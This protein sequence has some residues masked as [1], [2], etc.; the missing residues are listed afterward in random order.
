M[1]DEKTKLEIEEVFSYIEKLR[2]KA[3]Q[4]LY[5]LG[6]AITSLKYEVKKLEQISEKAVKRIMDENT[7]NL[8]GI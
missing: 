4:S 7:P 5:G 6:C 8:P 1:M 3:S 2:T